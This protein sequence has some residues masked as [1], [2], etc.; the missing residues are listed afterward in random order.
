M[1]YKTKRSKVVKCDLTISDLVGMADGIFEGNHDPARHG[2]VTMAA[3]LKGRAC[4]NALFPKAHIA[5]RDP[6]EGLP[7]DWLGFDINVPDVIAATATKLPHDSK[8][9]YF[10]K[11]WPKRPDE[12]AEDF[13][14]ADNP[15]FSTIRR[16]LARWASDNVN[17][18]RRAASNCTQ[19]LGSYG[20]RER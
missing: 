8:S 11:M 19:T 13:A 4:V 17:I 16:K 9:K 2:W 6:G 18:A 20:A 3:N 5:W 7:I 1:A 15:E 12:K 14:Y 10:L